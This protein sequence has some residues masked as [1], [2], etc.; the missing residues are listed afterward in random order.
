MVRAV[1]AEQIPQNLRYVAMYV[2]H[3]DQNVQQ[4]YQ[5]RLSRFSGAV[6]DVYSAMLV[7]LPV[8]VDS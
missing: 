3:C 7:F 1:T 2:C 4:E 5:A 8:N 6:D